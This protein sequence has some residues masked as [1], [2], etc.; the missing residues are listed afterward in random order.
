VLRNAN[1]QKEVRSAA[2]F[3]ASMERNISDNGVTMDMGVSSDRDMDVEGNIDRYGILT[4]MAN[5]QLRHCKLLKSFS[6]IP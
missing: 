6:C 3:A 4:E 5:Q 1:Q 2:T